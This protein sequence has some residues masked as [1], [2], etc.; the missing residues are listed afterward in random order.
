MTLYDELKRYYEM[1]KKRFDDNPSIANGSRMQEARDRL[2]ELRGELGELTD[3]CKDK[4]EYH[5]KQ[6]EEQEREK[7]SQR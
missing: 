3:E 7:C 4:E 1:A 2:Q 5:D 6:E